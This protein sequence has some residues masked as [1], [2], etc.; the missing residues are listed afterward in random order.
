[1]SRT[2]RLLMAELA[3]A[4]LPNPPP[5]GSPRPVLDRDA[6][7]LDLPPDLICGGEIAPGAGGC[8]RRESLL[9]PLLELR[10]VDV[11]RRDEVEDAIDQSERLPRSSYGVGVLPRL[12]ELC[13]RPGDEHAERPESARGVQ[14]VGQRR[15][16]RLLRLVRRGGELGRT[17]F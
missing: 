6:A 8:P 11:E 16:C 15:H 9:D 2:P 14:V 5:P 3:N 17:A 13:V 1:M 10:V 4:P 7:R 12:V